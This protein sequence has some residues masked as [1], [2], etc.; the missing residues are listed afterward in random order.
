[1]S[2]EEAARAA[3]DVRP[4]PT[5]TANGDPRLAEAVE[6]YRAALKAGRPLSRQELYARY[7]DLAATLA[8]CL[9]ALEFM[10]AAVEDANQGGPPSAA[11]T[12]TGLDDVR[13]GEPLGDF[14]IL[15]EVGRGG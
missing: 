8:Q 12:N 15:R 3:A 14:R 10:H 11:L 4:D 5:D 2:P 6:E 7:P 1:M 13:P 9:S